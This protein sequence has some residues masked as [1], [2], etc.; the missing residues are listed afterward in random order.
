[1][2]NYY[3]AEFCMDW[4]DEFDVY[5]ISVFNE[6][7]YKNAQNLFETIRQNPNLLEEYMYKGFGSNEEL[8]ATLDEFIDSISF[9]Q[10]TA[11][12]YLTLRKFVS[13]FG[14]VTPLDIINSLREQA[15]DYNE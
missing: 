2:V 1:M 6:E 13:E 5:G 11:D 3:L 15:E 9:T 10:V 14:N 7:E 8:E 12:E 4:A